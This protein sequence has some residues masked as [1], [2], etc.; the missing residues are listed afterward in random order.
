M[1]PDLEGQARM[2]KGSFW[3]KVF[4]NAGTVFKDD[5][6]KGEA[7][8]LKALN[9]GFDLTLNEFNPD[10][11]D[12]SFKDDFVNTARSLNM[13]M[14]AGLEMKRRQRFTG[15]KLH[16]SE[17]KIDVTLNKG[18]K[19]HG[20]VDR[21]DRYDNGVILWD[22]KTGV[23]PPDKMQLLFVKGDNKGLFKTGYQGAYSIQLVA[24]LVMAEKKQHEFMTGTKL[25]GIIGLKGYDNLE[26]PEKIAD[27][28]PDAKAKMETAM[29]D[30]GSFTD[31]NIMEIE[32]QA[33]SSSGLAG[34]V[35]CDYCDFEPVCNVLALKGVEDDTENN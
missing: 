3:H 19:L 32:S 30:F 21:I 6:N 31:K 26:D 22:Y 14:F 10:A 13:P 8:I 1:Q 33:G 7:G 11:F 27:Q 17:M 29:N 18:I 9:D 28:Y 12:E 35:S 16:E 25:A 2:D 15:L 23:K 24:Y 5:F 34:P 20:K 4:Q